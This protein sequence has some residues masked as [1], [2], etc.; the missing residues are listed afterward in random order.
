M[1][2]EN[3]FETENGRASPLPHTGRTSRWWPRRRLSLPSTAMS[4]AETLTPERVDQ[5]SFTRCMV[6]DALVARGVSSASLAARQAPAGDPR[7]CMPASPPTNE[8]IA[9]SPFFHLR[10]GSRHPH[11]GLMHHTLAAGIAGFSSTPGL[12]LLGAAPPRLGAQ[13]Q[14]RA[15][16]RAPNRLKL[17]QRARPGTC[18]GVSTRRTRPARGKRGNR[19]PT[20]T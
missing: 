18:R 15:T 19:G 14:R 9:N 11:A 7:P 13:G 5:R 1:D 8:Q 20:Q 16:R 6:L 4:G 12:G 17:A 10:S 3:G 2:D